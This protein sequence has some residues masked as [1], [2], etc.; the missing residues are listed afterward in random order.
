[1]NY[2]SNTPANRAA[3]NQENLIRQVAVI[4]ARAIFELAQLVISA[5]VNA[6]GYSSWREN[7]PEK[8]SGN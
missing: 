1:M 2:H 8:K 4:L 6:R 3:V 7:K 5:G